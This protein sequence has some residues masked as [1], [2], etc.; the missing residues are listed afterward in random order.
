MSNVIPEKA[1]TI[2]GDCGYKFA[3]NG[4]NWFI[5][6]C[7]DKITTKDITS[8]SYMFNASSTLT[9][10][11]F[12]INIGKNATAFGNVLCSAGKLKSVP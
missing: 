4:W 8:L 11:P 10:I 5:E 7:G 1:L 12:D 6:Q 2:T 3:T 9:E